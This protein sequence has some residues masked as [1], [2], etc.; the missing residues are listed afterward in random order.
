MPYNSEFEFCLSLSPKCLKKYLS[1]LCHM[2]VRLDCI[3]YHKDL[4]LIAV[5]EENFRIDI[6]LWILINGIPKPPHLHR[7]KCP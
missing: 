4:V 5:D 3:S 6:F 1:E 2:D 7:I